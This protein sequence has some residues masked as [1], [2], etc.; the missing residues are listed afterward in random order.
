MPKE[1]KIEDVIVPNVEVKKIEPQQIGTIGGVPIFADTEIVAAPETK[2]D[3]D[4][5]R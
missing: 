2:E 3:T 4:D 5:G 1:G